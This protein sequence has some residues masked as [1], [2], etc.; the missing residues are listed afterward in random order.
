MVY[1]LYTIVKKKSYNKIEAFINVE[2]NYFIKYG[3]NIITS[4]FT[5]K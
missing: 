1:I 3:Y 2:M 5:Y 4:E